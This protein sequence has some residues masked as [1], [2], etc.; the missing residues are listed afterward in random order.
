MGGVVSGV[1]LYPNGLQHS[2]LVVVEVVR[3]HGIAGLLCKLA[4]ELGEIGLEGQKHP[5]STTL[6]G[7]PAAP[8]CQETHPNMHQV[9]RQD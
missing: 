7:N 1:G 3:E 9:R 5:V 4:Q 2:F 8:T 6:L